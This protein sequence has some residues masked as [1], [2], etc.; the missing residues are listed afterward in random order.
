MSE[1]LV[2]KVQLCKTCGKEYEVHIGHVMGITIE[3]GQGNCP[4]CCDRITEEEDRREAEANKQRVERLRDGWRQECG[5]PFRFKDSRFDKFDRNVDKT[6]VKAWRQCQE[7][8]EKF[9]FR[10]PRLSKSLLMYSHGVWG[11][12]KTYLV[13]SVANTLIDK[14]NEETVRCPVLFIS[15]PQLF[16]RVR[17]SYNRRSSDKETEDEIYQRL[18]SVPLLI[19]DDVGKE[20]VSDLRFVQRVLFAIIDGRYQRMLPVV[21]TANLTPDELDLHFGGDRGNSASM[22]RLA[23]MTGNVFYELK[24]RSY[25]DVSN[26]MPDK[27]GS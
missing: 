17:A 26:R 7:Y 19:L 27:M 10:N 13:C 1:A 18:I 11:I 9:T 5:I 14:W 25:R 3:F 12:G 8:A 15:E 22:D 16:L 24:G 21:L 20:E 6:I 2:K 23:E 4:S